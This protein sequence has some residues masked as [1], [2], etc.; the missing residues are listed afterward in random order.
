[1][2]PQPAAGAAGQS[3]AGPDA[4][5]P[6]WME[7]APAFVQDASGRVTRWTAGAQAL[8]GHGVDDAL[9]RPSQSLLHT[10]ADAGIDPHAAC[11]RD[12][13]WS[14]RLWRATRDGRTLRVASQWFALDGGRILQID[15]ALPPDEAP[16]EAAGAADA[17]AAPSALE[18]APASAFAQP[19]GSRRR[20]PEKAVADMRKLLRRVADATPDV[21]YVLDLATRSCRFANRSAERVLGMDAASIAAMGEQLMPSLL[22]PEDLPLLRARMQLFADM[23]DGAVVT[24]EYRMRDASGSYRWF[25]SRDVVFERDRDGMVRSILGVA[26]DMSETKEGAA[27]M[28]ALNEQLRERVEELQV[29]LDTAPA[30]IIVAEDPHCTRVVANR[31][32]ERLLGMPVGANLAARSSATPPGVFVRRIVPPGPSSGDPA[33]LPLE[34][35]IAA[36]APVLNEEVEVWRPGLAAVRLLVDSAPLFDTAGMP[37][38]AVAVAL[39]VTEQRRREALSRA[40]ADLGRQLLHSLDADVVAARIVDFFVPAHADWCVVVATASREGA[41]PGVGSDAPLRASAVR[42]A[43]P[44]FQPL[45]DQLVHARNEQLPAEHPIRVAMREGRPVVLMPEQLDRVA[46]ALFHDDPLAEQRRELRV[47][48]LMALPLAIRGRTLGAIVLG[49]GHPDHLDKPTPARPDFDPQ[50]VSLGEDV[51]ARASLALDNAL[52]YATAR[53]TLDRLAEADRRKD[54]FIAMLAHELRNPLSPIRSGAA[55]IRKLPPGAAVTAQAE[56]IERQVRH[57]ARLVD[58]LLDASRITRGTLV[59]RPEPVLLEQIVSGAV[60]ATMHAIEAGAHRLSIHVPA[61]PVLLQAD[62]T[63]LV[64]ALG[65]LLHNAAKFSPRGGGIELSA[66]VVDAELVIRV[67]DEGA[68]IATEDLPRIFDLFAQAQGNRAA[69]GLAPHDGTGG[70]GIG[71]AL[72]QELVTLHEG[73]VTASSEGLG[74]GTTF[75]VRLPLAAG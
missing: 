59:I 47:G 63:R 20:T 48:A 50:D 52:L 19:R 25:V 24:T 75:E 46:D 54:E 1:M 44:R 61:E 58:D 21:V 41:D 60:E 28:Q 32:Y 34:R 67:R 8:Y 15:F 26:R 13:G 6:D 10:C 22:H 29:L 7:H 36:G 43:S 37:R 39:D 11:L 23:R 45:L 9:H 18:S 70:L 68:G 17:A 40:V 66:D 55:L 57:L 4:A 27:R 33:A 56:M 30:G 35:A 49:R 5:L 16:A 65:N 69:G 31:W 72:V 14:G 73:S 42:H 2:D 64:Q 71:L 12:G 53:A 62:A 38:G 74:R 51:A 3:P